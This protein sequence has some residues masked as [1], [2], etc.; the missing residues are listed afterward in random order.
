MRTFAVGKIKH[1]IEITDPTG[2]YHCRI[3]PCSIIHPGIEPVT[4]WGF[5]HAAAGGKLD[6]LNRASSGSPGELRKR[7]E[8]ILAAEW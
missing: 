4:D 3:V 1:M 5:V 2:K 6:E 7:A 8:E